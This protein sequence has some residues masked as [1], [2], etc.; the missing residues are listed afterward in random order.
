MTWKDGIYAGWFIKSYEGPLLELR[1]NLLFGLAAFLAVA[2]IPPGAA[3]GAATETFDWLLKD[4]IRPQNQQEILP[5][6]V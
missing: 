4:L 3:Q 6:Y 1:V 2:T 5:G